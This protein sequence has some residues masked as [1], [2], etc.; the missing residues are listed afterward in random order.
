MS[1]ILT[2]PLR[3][4]GDGG[5]P[6]GTGE[7]HD[8]QR[9][10]RP[11][12]RRYLP[13]A[14]GALAAVL[15]VAAALWAGRG[16]QRLRVDADRLRV[17]AVERGDFLEYVAVNA[18]AQPLRTI[19]LDAVVGGQVRE[20]FVE[21][22]A[23]VAAGEPLLRLENDN[24]A[25]Q[26]MQSEAQL[27]EQANGIRN[28]RLALDQ[29]Q[30]SLSQQLAELDYNLGRAR[31]EYDRQREL[32]GQGL[33]AAQAYEAARDELAYLQRRR[34][35]TLQSHRQDSVS[36]A[37]QIEQMRGQM[38]RLQTNLSF[39]G[40][41]VDNLIVRAPVAGQLTSLDAEIGEL[42]SQGS[43]LGQIDVIGGFRLV[44][45]VDEHY[46]ARVAPGQQATA[47]IG[48]SAYGLEVR[49][50]YPE[51]TNGRF[52]VDLVFLDPPPQT[53]RRGRSVQVRL[54]LGQPE[55]ALLLERGGFFQSTGGRWAYVVR[56]GQAERVP[57]TLGRQNP[58][59]FEVTGG[60]EPGDR[61]VTSSYDTFGDADVLVLD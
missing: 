8:R 50:V 9:S 31:R 44:A 57:I 28:T 41:T 35:L 37:V 4:S 12:W 20:R 11:L 56:G 25:L 61:V 24:L 7:G 54:Q 18:S 45:Q 55:T 22:G 29:N 16:G 3:T 21:E 17:A 60:L 13:D 32:H 47:Q 59:F 38:Q 40:Q 33:V 6:A 1:S 49:K 51:V 36:R 26:Q 52:Q 30:L 42:K 48:G 58:L 23:I 46:V 27:A 34:D 53:L 2:Q 5:P 10:P 14:L 39:L 19:L 43:R 15:L